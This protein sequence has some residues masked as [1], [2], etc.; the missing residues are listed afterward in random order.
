LPKTS[1]VFFKDTDGSVPTLVWIAEEVAKRDRRAV[2]K[3]RARLNMLRADG[4]DLRRPVADTLAEGIYRLL[5]FFA[6][7]AAAVVS[8]GCT[9]ESKVPP[10][11]IELAKKRKALFEADPERHIYDG[12]I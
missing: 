10:A 5:Y 12:E 4:R 6:G 3:L 7:T 9:K 2:A 11:E 8:H 1:V